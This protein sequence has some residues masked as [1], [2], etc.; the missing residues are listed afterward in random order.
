MPVGLKAYDNT[1]GSAET[2]EPLY[3][4]GQKLI[5]LGVN[6]LVCQFS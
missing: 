1:A 2:G 5:L 6:W 3:T 4:A